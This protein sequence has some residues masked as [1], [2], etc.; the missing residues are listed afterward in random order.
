VLT[1]KNPPLFDP[2]NDIPLG[3]HSVARWPDYTDVNDPEWR[4]SNECTDLAW[5]EGINYPLAGYN[6]AASQ[7]NKSQSLNVLKQEH[8]DEDAYGIG[9]VDNAD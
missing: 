3:F 6:S 2:V 5:F 4:K 7:F 1:D 9:Q 8:E